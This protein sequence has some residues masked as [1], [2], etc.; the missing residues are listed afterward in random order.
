[1]LKRSP[2]SSSLSYARQ[3]LLRAARASSDRD[4]SASR[5]SMEGSLRRASSD[6]AHV[7]QADHDYQYG[8]EDDELSAGGVGAGI[9]V[10]GTARDLLGAIS[11]GIWGS[12]GRSNR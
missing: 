2:S 6:S 9:N 11:K 7:T 8:A 4:D 12:L 1:M 10:A 5:S 3:S